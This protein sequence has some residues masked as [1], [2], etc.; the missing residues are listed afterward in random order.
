MATPFR[1]ARTL[2]AAA[3]R[4]HASSSPAPVASGYAR[5]LRPSLT[6]F[7]PSE[8]APRTKGDR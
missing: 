4:R 2:V 5:R 8:R 3:K 7:S 6:R 1:P